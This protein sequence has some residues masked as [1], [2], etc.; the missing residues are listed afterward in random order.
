NLLL[1][2]LLLLTWTILPPLHQIP[3]SDAEAPSTQDCSLWLLTGALVMDLDAY[4]PP[5]FTSGLLWEAPSSGYPSLSLD[6]ILVVGPTRMGGRLCW[7]SPPL[8]QEWTD[9]WLERTGV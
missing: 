4:F 9:C 2:K 6:G 5:P 3:E 7:S 8:L 1:L